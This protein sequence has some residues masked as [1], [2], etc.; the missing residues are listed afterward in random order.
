MDKIPKSGSTG[1]LP[2]SSIKQWRMVVIVTVSV[3]C[4]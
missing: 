4:L 2:N 3:R 1:P